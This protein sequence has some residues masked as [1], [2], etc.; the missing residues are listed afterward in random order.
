MPVDTSNP[1]IIAEIAHHRYKDSRSSQFHRDRVNEAC[2]MLEATGRGREEWE[3]G[4]WR[5][6]DDV[7]EV[8]E[9]EEGEREEKRGMHVDIW[10]TFMRRRGV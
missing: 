1:Y 2:H 7:Y 9:T 8:T 6:E 3:E 5:M 10:Q 4:I